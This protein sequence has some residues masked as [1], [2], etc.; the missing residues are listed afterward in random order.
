V[1]ASSDG[2]RPRVALLA[3]GC[4]ASRADLDAVAAE[5]HGAFDLARR[6]ERADLVVVN[7]CSVTG[8]AASAARQ[9]IRRAARDH[10]GAP[11]VAAGC[12]AELSP[13]ELAAL[14]GVA[15]V[16]GAR[17]GGSVAAAV[18]RLGGALARAG[19]L[20]E[21]GAGSWGVLPEAPARHTRPYLKIQDGCDRRC[22]YCV[23][24]LARGPS[25][26]LPF[27]EALRRLAR[28]GARHAEVVLT[29][30][31]L[32]GYG[33][34][35]APERSLADLVAEAVRRGAIRR[36]RLSS[37][38][39]DELPREL[40]RSPAV[41]AVLCPH[42]HLPLQ[43]GSAGVLATMGR[44][45]GPEVFR[46]AVAE[47][48]RALPG[49]CVG[50]DVIAG[51][52]G[53]AEEDHAAT[54]ALVEALPLAYLHVFPFSPRP[55]TAA[56]AFARRVPPG[57]VAE[58][59]RALRAVSERKWRA[60]LTA[61]IGREVE[62]IVEQVE[63]PWARGTAR[64]WTPLRWPARGDERGAAVR[65]RVLRSDGRECLGERVR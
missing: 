55:G 19:P 32:G 44:P 63:G 21:G 53:E 18:A 42:L 20:R 33:R 50:A 46:E 25:R 15:A 43:S 64:E 10:P 11:I 1:G 7:T 62:A 41:A 23:V 6:G 13:G 58:R 30:V 49:A 35:L 31:H 37:V 14:P 39:P 29:G 52:P 36:V 57:T 24:P 61:Q 59:A 54:V 60:F 51:F 56:A 28:L 12:H 5:L 16:V 2:R 22:S 3:L 47:V 4:R 38:E 45:Y 40:L 48:R 17:S 26:S 8:D 9:A 27:E 34:D 65:V